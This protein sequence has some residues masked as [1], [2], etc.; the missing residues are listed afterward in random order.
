[1]YVFIWDDDILPLQFKDWQDALDY[2]YDEKVEDWPQYI[3]AI[4]GA[5]FSQDVPMVGTP[6]FDGIIRIEWV[7]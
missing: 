1:M 6:V 4:P 5:D 7:Q 2:L 3:V